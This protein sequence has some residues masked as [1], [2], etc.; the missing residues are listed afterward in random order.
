MNDVVAATHGE[1]L[2]NILRREVRS[3]R[4]GGYC[5]T[6]RV[7]R[8]LLQFWFAN[9]ERD[10]TQQLFFAQQEAIE[11][12][13]YLNEVAEKSNVGQRILSD[14]DSAHSITGGLPRICFKMA[15]GTGKTVVMG[16]LIVYHF[17]NRLEYRSD[18][19]YA[20]NFL[21]VAPGITIRDRLAALRVDNRTGI[22][23]ADYYH[24]RMLVPPGKRREMQQLNAKIVIVNYQ[25]LQPRTLQG[26]KRSP[27]DGKIGSDG[28]KTEAK[29]DI[30]QVFRRILGKFKTDSR[31]LVIN[32]EA[33]HCYLPKQDDRTA[34]GEDAKT[35]NERAA[36]WFTGLREMALRFKVRSV[37]D[38][39]ATPYYLTG[40]G[41]EPYSLFEWVVS[42]FGLIEAIEAGLVKIPY[43]P[44]SDDTQAIELPVLRELYKHVKTELPRAGQKH[45]RAQAKAEGVVLK[46]E[47][48]RI[49]PLVK[50]AFQQ[51][52]EHYQEEYKN[53][54]HTAGA[55]GSKQ[56]ELDDSPP[57]FI[58]VCNNTSVSKEVYKYIAGYEQTEGADGE[59]AQVVAGNFDLFSNYDPG[60]LQQRER[61]PTLL[62]D[63]D[64]L[65]NSEQIDD[66]FR[67]V[68]APEILRFK[69]EYAAVH[70]QGSAE[71]L[72]DAQLLR[73]VVNTVGKRNALGSH[74]R[75]V[76]SVSMLTEGW[77]AN[78]VT[79]IA[80]LRAFGSQLLCEQVAGRALRRKSYF[81]TP[82]DPVTGEQL[83]ERA[84]KARKHENVLYKFPPEYAHIIGVPFKLFKGGKKVTPPVVDTVRVFP[85]RERLERCEITFPNVEGYRVEYP[86]G[87]V[88][89]DFAKIHDFEVDGSMLPTT[90]FMG[91]AVDGSQV[92]LTVDSV[93]ETREQQ[94]IY[95]I[96]KDLL[97]DHFTDD[98]GNLA[99]QRFHQLT[100]I[101]AEWYA[102]KVRVLHKEPKWKKLLYFTD[103]KKLVAHVSRAIDTGSNPEQRIRPILHYYNPI[104]SSR[105]VQG[106]TTRETYETRH[107]HVNLVVV[108]S[109]WEGRAAKI[110][111]DLAEEKTVETWVKNAF[112]DFRIPYTD[113]AGASRDYLPD[114][115][116]RAVTA[117]G[118]KCN[119]IIEVTGMT[120]D[121]VEKKWHVENRWLPAVNAIRDRHGWP[122]WD[123]L[124]VAGETEVA[125]FRNLLLSKLG[126]AASA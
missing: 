96:T 61:P 97:R 71:Q 107:S 119:V 36:V 30:S 6:T 52:Y 55:R 122:R 126:I 116:V 43:L 78:T 93:L 60:T 80:G 72:T 59:A 11:T 1:H 39:S 14:L 2:V 10:F 98:Q 86:D 9:P 33:H 101:V 70:G 56:L 48:P 90:T 118:E 89:Y 69:R 92:K 13:I 110:L 125:D 106:Q 57:V 3:W 85:L 88:S 22:D 74:I 35:E 49:P 47:P 28:E 50:A 67:K 104:G 100:A 94:I 102:T 40:S 26:N 15:T 121:K 76:V 20:D 41:H 108:D 19:R 81:L 17:F 64:A 8:E 25:A 114:F 45:K 5:S 117:E 65:E 24:V 63:S 21:L 83:S 37:Y 27:F 62:I 58:V 18:T 113:K 34:E 115:I 84:A 95:R 91:T 16:A 75:C 87:P 66:G 7:T 31:L 103:P 42:D 46:E 12:A 111:D 68:F 51:F 124:E 82:Y 54:Q 44:V 23:S 77:D 4:E 32:D 105:F 53:R 120:R 38:L 79:H 109:G 29:E 123:F 73:E 112:L 99:F